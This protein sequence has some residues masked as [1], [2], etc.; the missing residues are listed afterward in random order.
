MNISRQRAATLAVLA[1]ICGLLAVGGA[2]P[3][4]AAPA[5]HSAANKL[6]SSVSLKRAVYGYSKAFKGNEPVKA[7]NLLTTRC[8]SK[9]SLSYFTGIVTAVGDVYGP[10][11]IR[12][13]DAT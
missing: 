6:N 3:T 5:T 7:Y 4:S 8:R 1:L 2:A 9:M 13:F 12:S 10:Q 11:P